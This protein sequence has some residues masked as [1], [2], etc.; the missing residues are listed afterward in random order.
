VKRIAVA[1]MTSSR[2]VSANL[3]AVDELADQAAHEKAKVFFLPENFACLGAD[4]LMEIGRKETTVEGPIRGH[5]SA[6]AR[7]YNLWIVAGTVPVAVRPDGVAVPDDRVRAACFVYDGSGREV[8]RYDK[9][10]MFDVVV[11]DQHKHYKESETFEPGDELVVVSTP[12]GMMGLSVCYDIR[13][14]ELYRALLHKG[15]EVISIPS[16]FTRVTGAAHWN[17]LVRARAI[18][19]TCYVVGS[20]QWGTHD[21]GRETWGES[22]VVD[23]WGSIADTLEQGQGL[24]FAELDSGKLSTTRAKMPIQEQTRLRISRPLQQN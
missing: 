20:C 8:A 15:A 18:E 4:N 9:I 13:F 22:L 5:L 19:N 21:S 16:A 3:S 12:V 17:V 11:D 23:P 6:L 24:I 10:H 7:R 14:P 1:Q 2:E